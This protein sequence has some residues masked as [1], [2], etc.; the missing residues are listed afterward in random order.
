MFDRSKAFERNLGFLSKVEQEKLHESK[1]AIAGAGG[2]GGLLAVQLAR[3]GVGEI[4]LADP[5]PF[6]IENTNRQAVCRSNTIG[7]NKAVAVG[8]YLKEINPDINVRIYEDGVTPEN[9]ED[10]IDG[11][12]LVVDETEFTIH[13][14]GVMIARQA[15]K[16]NVPNLMALNIGFGALV[17]T[18]HPQGRTLERNL[19]LSET[20]SLDEIAATEVPVSR[21]LPYIPKYGD[22]SVLEKVAK[23]EKSAP[24]IAPG[25]AIAAGTGA[26]QAMLN[27]LHSQNNRPKPVY[28][29]KIM[30]IDSMSVEA[31]IVSYSTY[32]HYRHLGSAVILNLFKK[33]P[34]V[35]Y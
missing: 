28:A 21:W 30:I 15:R 6:E 10:F 24:S 35:D 3:L 16:Q 17:T 12:D 13:S 32:N 26:T 29:P 11:A 19:G 4:R 2:D 25:V 18:Y 7:E 14:L 5:D 8:D 1:I 20:A 31:K 9:V 23:G 22:I 34:E 27:L 33:V